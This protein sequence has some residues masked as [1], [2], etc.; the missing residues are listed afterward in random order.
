MHPVTNLS[1]DCSAGLRPFAFF[2]ALGPVIVLAVFSTGSPGRA[3]D[4]AE[5]EALA[6]TDR[7]CSSCHNDVDKEGGL[8][9]TS[10]GYTPG[11]PANLLTWVK[12]HDRVTSGEMPPKEKK[13]PPAEEI[14]AFIRTLVPSLVAAERASVAQEGRATRRR[15]NRAEY[16]STLRDIFQAPYL[17]VQ[18]QLPEDGEAFRFNKV[19]TALDVSYVHMARYMSAADTAMRQVMNVAFQ[20]PKPAKM[21]YYARDVFAP[22]AGGLVE[23][24]A[25]GTTRISAG[26]LR[27]KFPVLDT[28]AETAVREMTA[29][30]SVGAADPAKR[31][32]EA[33]GWIHSE[34]APTGISFAWSQRANSH[35]EGTSFKAMVNGRYKLR[36][37]GYTLWVGPNGYNTRERQ[38]GGEFRRVEGVRE[39]HLPDYDNIAPGRRD[40]PVIIYSR[41]PIVIRRL[42]AFDL[43]PEPTTSELDVYLL[44]NDTIVTDSSRFFRS[45]PT[46]FRGGFTNP[47]AQRDG[48][49]AV[50]FR[51]MEV[52]GPFDDD[53]TTAG[54]RL[55]FDDLPLEKVQAGGV[56]IE[57][58]RAAPPRRDDSRDPGGIGR[59]SG[60]DATMVTPAMLEVVSTAPRQDAERLMR[61]F[62][63]RA[64]RRPVEEKEV[65]R[66]LGLIHQRLEA[67]LGFAAAML[68]G[69][70]AVLASPEFVFLD[71]KPG[72]LDDYALATR[73]ALFLWNSEPDAALRSLAARGELHRPEVLR[74][75]TRRLLADARSQRLVESFLDY[76]LEIRKIDDASPSIALYTDYYLD[77]DLT[78]SALEE[79]RRY[80]ADMLQGNRP[81]RNVVD[82]DYAFL[83]ERLAVHYGIPGVKGVAMRRVALPADSPRG[84][85]MTQASVLKVTANGTTTS[86]VVRGKWIM[87]RIVGHDLPPPPAA[88]PAVEPDIRGA[89]TIRQQLEKH[90]ADESCAMCHRKI[91]PPGFA[92]ESF[93]V[94]GGW[95]DRYRAT[96]L[97]AA[98]S[99]G[100]GKNGWPFTFH[101]ALPVDP[102]GQLADGRVFKDVRDFKRILLEDETQLARNLTRQLSIY[103]TGAPVGF[104]DR[105]A[106]EGILARTKATGHGAASLIEEIVQSELFL[107]K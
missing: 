19:S 58:V 43:T 86:P 70:T 76:W 78:E 85:L 87:E 77:D 5:T 69:Y 103:A 26:A 73:L 53:A 99:P 61:N 11:E 94:M 38:F 60:R 4:H 92:L 91:D 71:E 105:A 14:G 15:L 23:P 106:I 35:P 47:L 34:Y 52:E 12:V 57:I 16:E 44:A 37:S 67:G 27:T 81:A 6:F 56:P 9:L 83:N 39:W 88:V 45:R 93:D 3:A 18:V 41:N 40:E 82:S 1:L 30:F 24:N 29:P 95:R 21:R 8:D 50:A 36:F 33:V 107:N 17:R 49:P 62:I 68:A 66:F 13:R 96:S 104:S 64:Y 51:W 48:Q 7:Y 72:R 59:R 42:G 10:V 55:L 100:F 32:R 98:P 101:E 102:S 65:R 84:G 2:S 79:T 20:R 63:S 46:G 31:E 22:G 89:V 28:Q 74:A 75:E 54:Y 80:F 90:R 97:N 25:I